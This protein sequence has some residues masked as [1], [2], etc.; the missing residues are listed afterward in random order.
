MLTRENYRGV[1]AYPPTP[2]TRDFA[3]D[4]DALRENL[5]KLIALGVEGIAM[6]GTSGEFYTL[7]DE[8]LRRIAAIMREETVKAGVVS[9]MGA[10]SLSTDET[11]RR[12]R[13]IAD[14]GIDG[15]L[16]IAP[17][18]APLT[19]RELM[20]FWQEVCAACPGTGVV[21][22]HYDWIRQPYTV[23][24]FRQ[25]AAIPNLVGSKEA[26][27]DF[28]LWRTM[29]LDSPLAHMS[30]TDVGWLTELHSQRAIGVG[31]LQICWMPHRVRE[32]LDLCAAGDYAAAGRAQRDFTEFPARMKL[33]LGRPHIFPPELEALE[34]YSPLARHKAVIDALGFLRAGPVRRPALPVPENLIRQ[35]QDFAERYY[36]ELIPTPERVAAVSDGKKLWRTA[37][38]LAVA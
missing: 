36:P 3:L 24:T 31:S 29:H 19:R 25:L 18:H 28:K 5:Q 6:A 8:E 32:I 38:E 34:A 22:Y 14:A 33:G 1:I 27:W 23:E 13:L 2:F 16:V 37:A 10:I 26:H 4:E 9:L 35:I 12:A 30:S 15:L 11:L 20:Q 17:Y 7:T 21:V